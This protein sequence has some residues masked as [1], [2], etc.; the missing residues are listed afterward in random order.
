MGS[1]R[2]DLVDAVCRELEAAGDPDRAKG[3]QAYMKSA[4]PFRGITS[5]HLKATLRPLLTDPAYLLGERD[6]WE[7]TIRGLWDGAQFREERYAALAISGHRL[8]RGWAQDRSAMP[9]YL[10]LIETGA[11]WDF[12]DEIA[13]RRVGPVL[14]AHPETEAARM[15]SWATADS[16]WV[17]RAAILSQLSSKDE[18]DRQ[19]LLDCI[20]PNLADREFF[21]RKAIGWS[22]RQYAHS[23][24]SAADW[25][26]RS[27]GQLDTRLSPLSRR[28]ALKN[29]G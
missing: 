22:L 26:R 18:T 7:A 23:G 19:L 29:L 10:Y 2:G 14:R 27:V 4:M 25:V 5:P 28:E 12:V 15:R 9:L 3:Q 17:R 16:M 20:T 24:T 6:E 21:V 8:Y 13:A 1:A 11:W